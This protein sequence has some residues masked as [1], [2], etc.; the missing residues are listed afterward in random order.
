MRN[1]VLFRLVNW[2]VGVRWASSL[3]EAAN[4]VEQKG[5][6]HR[7]SGWQIHAYSD[8]VQ[9]LQLAD[10]IKKPIIRKPSE[11]LVKVTAS[12][13]NPIDVAMMSELI[14]FTSIFNYFLLILRWLRVDAS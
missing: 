6:Q 2:K 11:L 10:N 9:E 13:V 1:S 3:A 14:E 12:S 7:M 8:N 5:C 4:P